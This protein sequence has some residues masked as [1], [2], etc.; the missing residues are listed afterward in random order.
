MEQEVL[1][2]EFSALILM[3]MA[4][5]V[6]IKGVPSTWLAL[7]CKCCTKRHLMTLMTV[8][9]MSIFMGVVIMCL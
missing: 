4:A 2:P 6:V 3:L 7:F 9:I 1:F 8:K 5:T